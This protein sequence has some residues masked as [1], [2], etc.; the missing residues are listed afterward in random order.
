MLSEAV[1][2]SYPAPVSTKNFIQDP[3][4]LRPMAKHL[5]SSLT[6][7]FLLALLTLSGCK[8][9]TQEPKL[10]QDE[11]A[12]CAF[13][14]LPQLAF[15]RSVEEVKKHERPTGAVLSKEEFEGDGYSLLYTEYPHRGLVVRKYF[16]QHDRLVEVIQLIQPLSDVIDYNGSD[17]FTLTSKFVGWATHEG[18]TFFH[19]RIRDYYILNEEKHLQLIVLPAQI[20]GQGALYAEMHFSQADNA[21]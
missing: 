18:F 8:R 1:K 2:K 13:V 20:G 19:S 11:W 3:V 15:G 12:D 6:P 16:F 7:L 10:P 5:F 4:N 21:Q 9:A 17:S 14:T